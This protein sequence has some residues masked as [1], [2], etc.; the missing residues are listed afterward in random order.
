MIKLMD[1]AH[2]QII[3]FTSIFNGTCEFSKR[4]RRGFKRKGGGTYSE[5]DGRI[6][7]PFG[8][9]P[10]TKGYFSSDRRGGDED[11]VEKQESR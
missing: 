2:H 4:T 10:I 11:G 3:L 6:Q 1:N 9:L 8:L 7:K 5:G